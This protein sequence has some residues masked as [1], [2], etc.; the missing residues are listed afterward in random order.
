MLYLKFKCYIVTQLLTWYTFITITSV[1]V[2]L[3]LLP[4]VKVQ[5]VLLNYNSNNDLY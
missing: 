4:D 3:H 1:L 5:Y 2:G